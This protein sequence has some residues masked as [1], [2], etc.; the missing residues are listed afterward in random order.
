MA[1]PTYVGRSAISY[2]TTPYTLP[3]PSG[4]QEGDLLLA[5]VTHWVGSTSVPAGW[6][7]VSTT[8]TSDNIYGKVW[9][10]IYSTGLS[11]VFTGVGTYWKDGFLVA[12][13][14]AGTVE[15]AVAQNTQDPPALTPTG[16]AADYLWIALYHSRGSIATTPP[17]NYVNFENHSTSSDHQTTA[18]SHRFLNAASENPSTYLPLYTSRRRTVTTLAVAPASSSSKLSKVI[19][20]HKAV[21]GISL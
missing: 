8:P 9:S 4:T 5:I 12:I 18:Y 14:N 2:Y 15:A 17:T 13:R 3:L 11:R 19:Q 7:V 21:G 1:F 20:A 10:A 16:G 6:S